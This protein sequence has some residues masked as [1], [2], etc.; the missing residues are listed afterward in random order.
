[1]FKREDITRDQVI[2]SAKRELCRRSFYFFVQT[3]WNVVISEPPVWNW[4]IEKLCDEL[5]A[6]AERI[7]A[8]QPANFDYFIINVPPGSS[9]STIISEM[10]PCWCWTID[11][12]QR[13]ICGS[14]NATVAEDI[15]DKCKKIFTSDLYKRLF[16]DVGIRSDAKT[17]LE[18]A[19]NGERYTTS[20]GTGITGIH[21]HQIIIDDPLNPQQAASEAEMKTANKWITETL[22]T[23]KVDKSIAITIIVMQRLHESDP[24][25]FLTSDK[26]LRINHIC[27]PGE[28]SNNVKPAEWG[29]FYK[30][31][32]FDP[33]RLSKEILIGLKAQLGSYGYSGQIQQEPANL[34]DGLIKK[35]WFDIVDIDISGL[36]K[37]FVLDTAYTAKKNNDPSGFLAYVVRDN[38]VIITNW[39]SHRLEFPDLVNY[40]ETFARNNG[41]THE[42]ILRVEPKA[43]GKS[44]VQQL[45]R[46]T[47]LNI[48]ESDNPEKDKVTRATSITKILESKRVKL[49]RGGWNEA[50][51]L[52]VCTFPKAAH[53]EAIDCLVMCVN[54]E[55]ADGAAQLVRYGSI[56]HRE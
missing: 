44:L 30:N 31:G 52:E 56:N 28:L 5:Q 1:M 39:E 38:E 16:P 32:L 2:T 47:N 20:T 6:E 43:S 36:P 53:D 26:K 55:L 46:Q 8:R 42:S 35:R 50:F 4:H 37:S 18:N 12:A 51:L 27:L 10:Y 29:K 22:S 25:G 21:A 48:I 24:T 17:H 11:V 33:V 54:E 41:Y 45:Y 49:L 3:F 15:A 19:H 13:F 14:H 9:K 23:R 40:T 34:E 7:K